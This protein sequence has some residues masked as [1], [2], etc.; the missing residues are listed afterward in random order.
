MDDRKFALRLLI[1]LFS[2]AFFSF[3]VIGAWEFVHALN[4]ATGLP[5]K[6]SDLHAS[7]PMVRTLASSIA[8]AYNTQIAL[9]L[10]FIALA[11]PITANFY[12][13]KLIEIFVRDP[14]NLFVLCS[15]ALLAGH[16]LFAVSISFDAWTGQLPFYIAVGAAVFGWVLLLPYYFYVLSFVDPLTIIKRVHLRLKLELEDAAR[17]RHPVAKSQQR[18]NQRIVN[19]GS[20][21]LR[22]VDRA[23]RDVVFDS[24]KAHM[25]ELERLRAVK[26]RLPDAFFRVDNRILIGA[27]AEAIE[28]LSRGR[29]WMEHRIATHMLLAFKI[30]LGKMPDGV[31]AM[32]AAV[33][34]EADAE[35]R[36]ANPEVFR[37]LVRLLNS[38][39]RESI[40]RKDNANAYIVV[41][42]Y[43]TLIRRLLDDAPTEVPTLIRHFA[44]YGRFARKQGLPFIHELIGYELASLAETAYDKRA[45][46]APDLLEA[47]IALEGVE[48]SAGSVKSRA[49]LAAYFAERG[50]PELEAVE[51]SLRAVPREAL[52]E[53]LSEI[54][55]ATEPVFWEMT[56]RGTDLDYVEPARRE[57]VRRVFG[58]LLT[59]A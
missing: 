56:D 20:V 13:P 29:I 45:E 42:N 49:L 37:L 53:A 3:G 46:V 14:V 8:T 22:A 7:A 34:D 2:V 58:R 36:D 59:E 9:L 4:P 41:F 44:Y 26:P 31:S 57:Q 43:R 51:R 17:G 25:L 54:M 28:I 12:T 11:I 5:V 19:L 39:V 21:L 50:M 23:D 38:F 16:A 55:G 33:M 10:T 52:Q 47:L 48:T 24:I 15:A 1:I 32:A 27:S 35:A 40:K 18:V 6:L 30:V